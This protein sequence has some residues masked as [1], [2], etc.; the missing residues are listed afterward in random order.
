MYIPTI[1]FHQCL[2]HRAM[3]PDDP[4]P[5]LSPLIANYLK[6][7]QEVQTKCSQTVEKMKQ[8][9]KLVKHEKKDEQAGGSV[10][11]DEY[12]RKS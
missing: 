1:F 4:L 11:K 8:E 9:F 3:Q 5:D 6:P 7:P 12:V 10:F 2:Q